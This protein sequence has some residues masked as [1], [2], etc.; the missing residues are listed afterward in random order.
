MLTMRSFQQALIHKNELDLTD[1]IGSD[2]LQTKIMNVNS[3]REAT[4]AA[5]SGKSCGALN[6]LLWVL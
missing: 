3:C 4:A 1:I 5:H 6:C 2:G